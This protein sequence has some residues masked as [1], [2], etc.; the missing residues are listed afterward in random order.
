MDNFVFSSRFN[1]ANMTCQLVE[2]GSLNP[3]FTNWNV[4]FAKLKPL[5]LG[6]G[7]GCLMSLLGYP[8]N[9]S[10]RINREMFYIQSIE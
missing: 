6:Q 9:Y 5:S 8:N 1:L 4:K 10:Y 2:L 7:L 3:I